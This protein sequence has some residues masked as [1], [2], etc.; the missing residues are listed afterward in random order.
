M[1]Q[2]KKRYRLENIGL[3]AYNKHMDNTYLYIPVPIGG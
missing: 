3:F 2:K 1:T